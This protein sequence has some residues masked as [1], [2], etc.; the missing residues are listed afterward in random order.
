MKRLLWI[1]ILTVLALVIYNWLSGDE[2]G[3][4]ERATLPVT[5]VSAYKTAIFDTVEALGTANA[6]ESI[7][8]TTNATETISE[9][10]FDD[11][12]YVAKGDIIAVLEQGEEQAQLRGAQAQLKEHERELKRLGDLFKQKAAAKREYDERETLV[13]VTRQQLKE[14]SARVEERTLRA[15]FEGVLGI[16]R[17]SVGSL[18]QPGDIITTLD[19]VDPIK[20]DFA[21]P[22]IYLSSLMSG[23]PIEARSTSYGDKVFEGEIATVNSRVDPATRSVLVRAIVPNPE[24]VIK[25]GV[26]M[27]VTLLKDTREALVIPEEATTQRQQKQFVMVVNAESYKVEEREITPGIRKNGLL[28]VLDGVAE[29]EFVIVRGI[30][31]VSAGQ[32]VEIKE[33]WG[34]AR[35]PKPLQSRQAGE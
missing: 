5:V 23:L 19:D 3:R 24:G 4:G 34:E 32:A 6:N 29:G 26:L 31:Q 9:I 7:E 25:P 13:E 17:L 11:G 33:I 21:V 8:I 2:S 30:Q 10:H 35:A 20:L 1:A 14:I 15:P 12:Q 16:R 18:V 27:K 22:D 28:E